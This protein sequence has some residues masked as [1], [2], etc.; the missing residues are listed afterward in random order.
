A[1]RLASDERKRCAAR[2]RAFAASISRSRGGAVVTRASSNSCAV[3]VTCSTARLK[4]AWFA[5][6][7]RVN[8][9]SLRTNCSAEARISSSVAGGS[10]LCSV[11]MFR[12]MRHPRS[13]ARRLEMA[14]AG[15]LSAEYNRDLHLSSPLE[16]FDRHFV[17]VTAHLEVDARLLELQIAQR[18]FIQERRQA[19]VAQADCV[20]GW[21]E[22]QPE[23]GLDQRERRGARPGLRRASDRIVG[24]PASAAALKTAEQLGQSP[25]LH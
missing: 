9:L 11:L 19:R 20:R 17:G 21:I 10:K 22:L 16:D 12:H 14:P 24:R 13:D 18:Q 8:P 4:A 15:S 5:L 3:C 2:S 23:R 25:H 6:E 7:G 1:L